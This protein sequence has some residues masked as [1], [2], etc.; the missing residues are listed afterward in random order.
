MAATAHPHSAAR[1]AP[2]LRERK[3]IKT[4]LAIR[5]A[6][7]RL[8]AERG[9]EATTIEQIA[10]A[11]E[12]S[13]STVFRY[14]PSKEDIVLTDEADPLPEA[15]LRARPA[16]E[17]PIE[18]LRALLHQALSAMSAE[19]PEEMAQRSRLLAEVPA[20]RARM[21]ESASQAARRLAMVIAER[22][23][24]DPEDLRVRVFTS[25][26]LSALQ[27]TA[28]YW[29]ERGCRD[30]PAALLDQT[31]DTLEQGLTP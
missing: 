7:Y 23:G 18:S 15:A 25:A 21:T 24:R 10:Q 16:D 3:K 8:I 29:A 12:V 28:V 26:V 13:P 19:A 31:L 1:A 30:D 14:F 2:G 22:T 20:V 11:A 6:T 9:Y 27:E 5:R 4:R 17:P